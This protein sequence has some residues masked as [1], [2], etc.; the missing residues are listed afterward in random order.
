VSLANDIL[1]EMTFLPTEHGGRRTPVIPGLYRPQF[2]Y[3]NHD[4]DVR[5]EFIDVT[6]VKPGETAKAYVTFMSP[7]EHFGNLKEGDHFLIR[8]GQKVVAYGHVIQIIDLEKSAKHFE[9]EKASHG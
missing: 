2:Y 8:E 1:V 9:E 4:W 5:Y 7:R 3:K 6:K